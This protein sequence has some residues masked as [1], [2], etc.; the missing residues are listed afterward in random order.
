[1][2]QALSSTALKSKYLII[3]L[4]ASPD[5]TDP[6][7][8]FV[9][10]IVVIVLKGPAAGDL[11]QLVT[12]YRVPRATRG[13]CPSGLCRCTPSVIRN[14]SPSSPAGKWPKFLSPYALCLDTLTLPLGP[15]DVLMTSS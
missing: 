3:I 6:Y 14:K 13:W 4:K 9:V 15:P 2:G 7:L 11:A 5:A 10:V 12:H 1:M 8:I